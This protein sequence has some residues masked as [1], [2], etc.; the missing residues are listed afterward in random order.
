MTNRRIVA[1]LALIGVVCLA[2]LA[3]QAVELLFFHEIGCPHC[4][5]I[6][7]VLDSLLPEYPELEVQ[8]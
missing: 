8:D 2:S 6:R 3:S 7:G 4:A 1:L 5:R